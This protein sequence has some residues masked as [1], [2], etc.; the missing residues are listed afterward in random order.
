MYALI[1]IGAMLV[2]VVSLVVGFYIAEF[3]DILKNKMRLRREKRFDWYYN[4]GLLES[5]Y[6][7]EPIVARKVLEF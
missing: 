7:I 1:I 2:A 6:L 5:A 4:M 3:I